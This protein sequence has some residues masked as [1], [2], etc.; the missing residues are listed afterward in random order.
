MTT[1]STIAHNVIPHNVMVAASLS[2]IGLNMNGAADLMSRHWMKPAA[3]LTE[4]DC[5]MAAAIVIASEYA[6]HLPG[7]H[8]VRLPRC[9]QAHRNAA[10]ARALA[11]PK[12]A[13]PSPFP[14]FCAHSAAR[15]LQARC[16]PDRPSVSGRRS[17]GRPPWATR[18]PHPLP[19]RRRA[20]R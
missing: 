16:R 4:A 5:L 2:I 20:R 13:R 10:R 8:L 12:A 1:F 3:D 7:W 17:P 11:H 18:R 6:G 14:T 9:L 19:Q 15:L